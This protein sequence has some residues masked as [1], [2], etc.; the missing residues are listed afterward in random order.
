MFHFSLPFLPLLYSVSA[1]LVNVYFFFS[2]FFACKMSY[3]NN[4]KRAIK[5][6]RFVILYDLVYFTFVFISNRKTK[7]EFY[8]FS[9]FY[10]GSYKQQNLITFHFINT[11]HFQNYCFANNK[12]ITTYLVFF[13][14]IIDY[15]CII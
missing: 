5:L 2:I 9:T 1:F 3:F 6:I 13:C 11:T 8:T 12:R 7:L 4:G 10:S 15:R 14:Q